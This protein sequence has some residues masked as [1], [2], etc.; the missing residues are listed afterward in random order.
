[1]PLS[2]LFYLLGYAIGILAFAYLAHRRRLFTSGVWNVA[3]AGLL[4]GLLGANLAQ[5][6]ANFLS[7]SP[8]P[9]GKTVIGGIMGGYLCV[10]LYKKWIGLKRPLGDLFAFA[11]CAG[12]AVGRFGCYFAGCC[13]GKPWNGAWAIHQHGA[14]RHPTQL[15]LSIAAALTFGV[16][17]LLERRR[18]LPENALFYIQGILFGTFRLGIEFFRDGTTPIFLSLNLAQW[19]CLAFI[20]YFSIALTFLLSPPPRASAPP[21]S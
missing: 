5:W 9:L 6:I 10:F 16:L 17:L 1:M 21:L 3:W 7:P 11:L 14:L 13:Y 19:T 12:E 20:T 2:A 18:R 15:Y 8:Y 4:G